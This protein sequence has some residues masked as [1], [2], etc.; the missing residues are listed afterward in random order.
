MKWRSAIG[1][2]VL[3]CVHMLVNE[4]GDTMRT[5]TL[6]VFMVIGASHAVAQQTFCT[7]EVEGQLYCDDFED[8]NASFPP[9]EWT[10]RLSLPGSYEV[11]DGS[12]V[13]TPTSA[14]GDELTSEALDILVTD[15]S[16][17]TRAR[18]TGTEGAVFLAARN[19][20]HEG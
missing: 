12:Y 17:R 16:L 18:F 6:I 15:V 20:N 11:R 8:G 13:L 9:V 3:S 19:Q 4:G 14:S 10:P 7:S 2:I 5:A 1:N